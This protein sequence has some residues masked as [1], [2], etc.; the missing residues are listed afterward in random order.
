MTEARINTVLENTIGKQIVSAT[1]SLTGFSIRLS[2][3][4]GIHLLADDDAQSGPLLR[5]SIVPTSSLPTAE[6]TVCAVDWSWI[7][8]SMIKSVTLTQTALKLELVPAGSL[9]I[10]VQKW[11]GSPFLSF[12]P[13]RPK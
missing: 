1:S 4:T 11:K 5:A 6:D 12:Q 13:F 3:A 9:T 10:S 8:Q 7:C 2:N